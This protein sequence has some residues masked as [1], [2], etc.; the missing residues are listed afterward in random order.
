MQQTLSLTVC[1]KIGKAYKG[2][3]EIS[4]F[5]RKSTIY[6]VLLPSFLCKLIEFCS[7][8]GSQGLPQGPAGVPCMY[9]RLE[10][11]STV[12]L[13]PGLSSIRSHFNNS[14]IITPYRK[15]L[16]KN[17]AEDTSEL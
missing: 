9:T 4:A 3:A 10:V 12:S 5:F 7:P 2:K 13:N 8:E 15:T 17:P 1:M 16:I 11:S 14:V 6:M